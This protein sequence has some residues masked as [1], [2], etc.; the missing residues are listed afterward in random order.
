MSIKHDSYK[1]AFG[2]KLEPLGFS[3]VDAPDPLHV[4]W[5]GP[6]G[7][8]IDILAYRQLVEGLKLLDP[9]LKV[10]R[11]QFDWRHEWHLTLPPRTIGWHGSHGYVSGYGLTTLLAY[12][13]AY[14]PSQERLNALDA[15]RRHNATHYAQPTHSADAVP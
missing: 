12:L 13:A 2:D 6:N 3:K 11:S 15:Q 8:I 9:G 10:P 5:V 14:Q 4:R 7:E 1:N